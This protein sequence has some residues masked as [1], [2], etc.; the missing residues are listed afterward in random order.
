MQDPQPGEKSVRLG[1]AFLS[2]DPHEKDH[3]QLL[4]PVIIVS[5][6]DGNITR[7]QTEKNMGPLAVYRK[8]TRGDEEPPVSIFSGPPPTMVTFDPITKAPMKLLLVWFPGCEEV[9]KRNTAI[10]EEIDDRR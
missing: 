5:N 7:E 6:D 3:F 9:L 10:K 1:P 2:P 8:M 4:R